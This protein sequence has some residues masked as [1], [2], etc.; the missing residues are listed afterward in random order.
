MTLSNSDG[1]PFTYGFARRTYDNTVEAFGILDSGQST[2]YWSGRAVRFI[3][4]LNLAIV[5]LALQIL[6][7]LTSTCEVLVRE[8]EKRLRNCNPDALYCNKSVTLFL[9]TIRYHLTGVSLDFVAQDL[10]LFEH[11][12]NLPFS[13]AKLD[14]FFAYYQLLI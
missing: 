10:Y 4:N 2:G 14:L 8:A 1:Y 3:L 12:E 7:C 5:D 6:C 13:E 9:S 11:N